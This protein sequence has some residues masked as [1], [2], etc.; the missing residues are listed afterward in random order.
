MAVVVVV[1]SLRLSM[2]WLGPPGILYRTNRSSCKRRHDSSRTY[3]RKVSSCVGTTRR[4]EYRY[5][6][7]ERCVVVQMGQRDSVI[8]RGRNGR[9]GRHLKNKVRRSRFVNWRDE[10]WPAP[11]G[12][13]YW[14][15]GFATGMKGYRI[16]ATRP[17]RCKARL[18]AERCK[19]VIKTTIIRE[20]TIDLGDNSCSN[21][22]ALF[23]KDS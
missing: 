1:D 14:C 5:R 13:L 9:N 22:P 21:R 7:N 19:G 4:D 11:F 6:I 17:L 20:L 23:H 10:R 18:K 3:C 12:Y 16:W 8:K 2:N 15:R